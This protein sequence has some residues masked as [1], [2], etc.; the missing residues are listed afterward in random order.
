MFGSLGLP[1]LLI[2]L[3][4]VLLLFGSRRLP[5]LAKGMGESI[6]AFKKGMADNQLEDKRQSTTTTETDRTT[7][8]VGMDR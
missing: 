6:R 5:E 3:L 2:V 8:K 4:L 1:E 7:E